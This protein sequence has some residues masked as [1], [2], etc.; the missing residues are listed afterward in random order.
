MFK[1]NITET[2]EYQVSSHTDAFDESMRVKYVKKTNLSFG[3]EESSFDIPKLIKTV[4]K[5]LTSHPRLRRILPIVFISTAI[6][7][8]ASTIAL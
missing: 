1:C 3:F 2:K 8:L 7:I 5:F 6:I 4:Y